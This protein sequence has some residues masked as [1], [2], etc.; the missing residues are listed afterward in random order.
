VD[1]KVSQLEEG[2]KKNNILIFG[3]EERKDE[4]YFDTLGAVMKVL[5]ESAKLEIWNG[6]ID[7][8]TRLGRRGQQPIL[9]KFTSSSVKVEVLRNTKNIAGS[10]I[11]VK[12][13]LVNG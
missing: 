7:Y 8:A 4:G 2:H 10:Q 5:R 9:V 12:D 1:S 13:F 3:L 11:R 6:S